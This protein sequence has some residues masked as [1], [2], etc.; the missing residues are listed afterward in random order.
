M[1]SKKI[2][3]KYEFPKERKNSCP[4][5]KNKNFTI[6]LNPQIS[7]TTIHKLCK[8]NKTTFVQSQEKINNTPHETQ[9][10]LCVDQ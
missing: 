6:P 9:A 4:T 5:F 3:S 2:F 7:P 10:P 1:Y 8:R